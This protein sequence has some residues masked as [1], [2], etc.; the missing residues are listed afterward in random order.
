MNRNLL[1]SGFCPTLQKNYSIRVEYINACTFDNPNRYIK[2][3]CTCDHYS[4]NGCE[5]ASKCPINANA[6]DQKNF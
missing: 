2:G 3:Y 4:T 5:I 1:C 6:P